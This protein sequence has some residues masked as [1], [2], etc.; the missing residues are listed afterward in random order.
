MG[1]LLHAE[2]YKL[3]HDKIYWITFTAILLFNMILL[4]GSSVLSFTGQEALAESMEKEIVTILIVCIYEGLFIGDDF[5]GRT[6]YHSLS[7]GKSRSSVLFAKSA[8]SLIAAD[9]LLFFFPLLLILTCTVKNGWGASAFVQPQRMISMTIAFLIL[10]F[11]VGGISLLAAVCFRD[12][13]RTIGIPI[14]LYFFMILLLNGS[15]SPVFSRILPVGI[16]VL[17]ANGS[18]SPY[19]GILIGTLW[20]AVLEA[21]SILI[22]RRSELR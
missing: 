2:F 6:L 22:F 3:V 8:V 17:L 12:V 21:V 15:A 9:G 7:A 13:G 10:G 5:A 1:R 4:S 11:A 20:I 19:Y 14:L 16:L 18:V